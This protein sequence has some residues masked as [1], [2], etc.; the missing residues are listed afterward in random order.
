V[1]LDGKEVS[2]KATLS[3]FD[4]NAAIKIATPTQVLTP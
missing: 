2:S 1:N 3:F 4:Y